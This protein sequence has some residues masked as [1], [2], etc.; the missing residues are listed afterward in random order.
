MDP[1]DIIRSI[2]FYISERQAN[3]TKIN[4]KITWGLAVTVLFLVL[5]AVRL[6]LFKD[7]SATIP[8]GPKAEIVRQPESWMNIY[9]NRK[10][11]GHP[12][13]ISGTGKCRRFQ[14]TEKRHHAD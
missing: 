9:Q 4:W 10:N 12:S 1:A 2:F 8:S 3:M 11:R 7:Q 14:T 6:G 5:L 13:N